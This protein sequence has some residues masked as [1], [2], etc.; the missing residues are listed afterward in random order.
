MVNLANWASQSRLK[1]NNYN[2]K[3]R[4]AGLL[5]SPIVKYIFDAGIFLIFTWD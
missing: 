3:N 1:T 4:W 2:N 5:E